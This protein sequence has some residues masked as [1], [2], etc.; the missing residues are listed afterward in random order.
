MQRFTRFSAVLLSLLPGLI[1]SAGAGRAAE[2]DDFYRGKT[3]TVVVALGSSGS[4]ALYAQL[5]QQQFGKFIPGKPAVVPQFMPGGGGTKGANYLY[6]VAPRDGTYL[7]MLSDYTSVAQ[8]VRPKAVKY[9]VRDFA[10]IGL[11]V[12]SNPVI[13]VM[14]S[15]GVRTIEDAMKRE[16]V[17]G[18]TGKSAPGYVNM[19]VMNDVIGTRF[20]IIAGYKDT[21]AS[22]LAM[23]RGEVA[24]GSS[25]WISWVARQGAWLAAGKII[26]LVQIGFTRVRQ[27]ADVPTLIELAKNDV[28]RQLLTFISG[29]GALGRSVTAPPGIPADRVAMLR[30]AFDRM[31]GDSAFIAEAKKRHLALEPSSGEA[32]QAAVKRSA[33]VSPAVA[34]RAR[35]IVN[36]H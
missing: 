26:P 30:R 19:K 29:G 6:N 35:A 5:M 8:V 16:L 25:A 18:T 36:E 13:M 10:W 1:L 21:G 34:A 3:I 33:T 15:S 12:P 17:M 23:E 9:D 22:E 11:F 14:A 20:K 24:G 27:L 4:Y 2:P 31:V 28:D 7:G 32:L